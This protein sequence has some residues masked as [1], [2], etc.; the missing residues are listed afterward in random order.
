MMEKRVVREI[1]V[2]WV[3]FRKHSI[4][5]TGERSRKNYEDPTDL[6]L[7]RLII[8]DKAKEVCRE[9]ETVASGAPFS[10]YPASNKA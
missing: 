1:G 7:K 2:T 5:D 9:I 3:D 6:C 10:D 4:K 8:M